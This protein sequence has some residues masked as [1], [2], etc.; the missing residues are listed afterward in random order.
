MGRS[1]GTSWEKALESSRLG[2]SPL[3]TLALFFYSSM[4]GKPLRPTSQAI[5]SD[6]GSEILLCSAN[7][8]R[9]AGD[10]FGLRVTKFNKHHFHENTSCLGCA[11]Y[12]QTYFW[13][14]I[15]FKLKPWPI[16]KPHLVFLKE[17][18][19]DN[20]F[21]SFIFSRATS[22]AYGGSKARSPIGAVAA[23]LC[24]SHSNARS[25]PHLW[26]TSQ[27]MTMPDP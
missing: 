19:N 13:L 6:V 8:F 9:E 27:L 20:Y 15:Y 2:L 12:M 24:Q 23:C 1:K 25:E 14:V 5:I 22:T 3:I 21:L 7:P 26:P 4:Q 11:K 10:Y 16:T 17:N 18:N